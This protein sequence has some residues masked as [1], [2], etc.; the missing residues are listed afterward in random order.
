[1]SG[2]AEL[3]VPWPACFSTLIFWPLI[4]FFPPS[5]L[6]FF[7]EFLAAASFCSFRFFLPQGVPRGPHP[8]VSHQL[9]SSHPGS[10]ICGGHAPEHGAG[11]G[12]EPTQVPRH[13]PAVA[14]WVLLLC[15][16]V[17]V[18]AVV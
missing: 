3:C 4:S 18:G 1:V 2:W 11:L 7:F 14:R 13:L 6:P 8:A 5:H 9:H 16:W 10:A 17:L 15:G 12:R